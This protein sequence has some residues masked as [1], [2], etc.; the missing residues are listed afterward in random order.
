MIYFFYRDEIIVF[1][2]VFSPKRKQNYFHISVNK[3]NRS[4]RALRK[5]VWK[6]IGDKST[7][8]SNQSL[9]METFKSEVEVISFFATT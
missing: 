6:K 8:F 2:I 7:N 1:I 3:L 9:H 4:F 5:H